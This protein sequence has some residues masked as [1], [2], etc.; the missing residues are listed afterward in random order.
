MRVELILNESELEAARE[1]C[2]REGF[3]PDNLSAGLKSLLR[4]G[5]SRSNQLWN[6]AEKKRL[7]K[8]GHPQEF[9]AYAP[10]HASPT[11]RKLV[12]RNAEAHETTTPTTPETK[13]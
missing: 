8:L 9:R 5:M 7:E 10:L 2:K 1:E 11:A 4:H 6:Y 3:Q 13:S 12:K